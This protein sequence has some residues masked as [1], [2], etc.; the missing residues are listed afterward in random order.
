MAS[1]QL[2]LD[3]ASPSGTITTQYGS[4][5]VM[6]QAT[7]AGSA[8]CADCGAPVAPDDRFCRSCGRPVSASLEHTPQHLTE[9]ILAQRG[10]LIGERKQV[11]VLFADIVGSTALVRE[12]DPEQASAVITPIVE[13]MMAA[14]HQFEG[15]VTQIAGDGI[16]ALFGAP[17]AV[18]DHAVRACYGAVDILRNVARVTDGSVQVRVGLHSGQVLVKAIEKDLSI[19]YTA[20]GATVHLAARLEKAARPGTA[21]ATTAT[22][23]LARGFV[24]SRPV[25]PIELAGY[26]TPVQV[27]ELRGMR[28]LEGT[29]Q[30]RAQRKLT[31][32]VARSGEM[33]VLRRA[34]ATAAGGAGQVVAVV[35]EA[36]VGK[37]RLL[38]EFNDVCRRDDVQMLTGAATPYDT[39]TPYH[40]LKGLVRTWAGLG[41]GDAVEPALA[42][43]L[44]ERS[45]V[46]AL[47]AM[48]DGR[49]SDPVW[50][51]LDPRQRRRAMR[52][53]VRSVLLAQ[54][55]QAPLLVLI[56]DLHWL[57]TE[58]QA[59]LD[60]LV[61]SLPSSRLL[62]VVTYRPEYEHTWASQASYTQL[63]VE[64]L[65]GADAGA[66]LDALLGT[67]PSTAALGTGL[68]ARSEGTPLFLEEWVNALIEEGRLVGS[69]GSY[70]LV[71]DP[72]D[73]AMP[74]TVQTILAAR[75]DRL[76]GALKSVLRVASV[77][78]EQVPFTLLAPLC[79]VD[80]LEEA[81]G[82]LEA[83][84]FLY[85]HRAQRE[86]REGE[87]ERQ[88]AGGWGSEWAFK[89]NL[90]REVVYGSTPLELRR[91]L[92][93]RV[94]DVLAGVQPEQ[95]ERLAHHAWNAQRWSAAARY[96]RAAGDK[97]IERSAYPAA[98]R[99]FGQALSALA[100]APQDRAHL[101]LA[102]DVRLAQRV[103]VMATGGK[104]ADSLA[105]L[106][107]ASVIAARIADGHRQALAEI[108]RSYAAS[109]MGDNHIGV[110]A[111]EAALSVA[112]A[113]DDTAVSSEARIAIAQ[114]HLYAG[115]WEPVPDLLAPDLGFLLSD[116]HRLERR[117]Q[118]A[119]RSLM[120]LSHLAMAY[121]LA[122][123]DAEAL[124]AISQAEQLTRQSRRPLDRC[125]VLW[126]AGDVHRNA[127]RSADA[128]PLLETGY[129]LAR[130]HELTWW[131]TL[132][133]PE[134]AA[135]LAADGR[136]VEAA[137]VIKR[138][139]QPAL[140]T[141]FPMNQTRALVHAAEVHVACG[142]PGQ[143]REHAMEA[144]RHCAGFDHPLFEA[145]ALRW[146]G[147][148]ATLLGDP[149]QAIDALSG[150]LRLAESLRAHLLTTSIR[151]DLSRLPAIGTGR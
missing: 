118:A 46:S 45:H 16:M 79:A 2:A 108:H 38:H 20:I 42:Q 123:R 49:P 48:L 99:F 64:P 112:R 47:T 94:V 6:G 56:E 90:T 142:E 91:R 26:T 33:A 119:T 75:V 113:M 5:N 57:D 27:H 143:A 50:F 121:S 126:S 93:G 115:R 148:A 62:L 59:V 71:G 12:I 134:L 78:G 105:E 132:L 23:N 89:H 129:G 72:T 149:Q 82:R 7:S 52:D 53:A 60:E 87:G 122:G 61:G 37:S 51:D 44:G 117:G 55:G 131:A 145:H 80:D 15:T 136:H 74:S 98:R 125:H 144:L 100:N 85:P 28:A 41:A 19:D 104:L 1:V 138:A 150:A 109:T 32:F 18:E 111:G 140:A 11:T 4:G 3:G 43:R 120:S 35:G 25:G 102:V 97:A 147:V 141:G 22:I 88:R 128:V 81:L 135:A 58:S 8:R 29:W 124:A 116:A 101:E 130:E 40:P 86:Q 30:V 17:L 84:E 92:H 73:V 151:Q 24:D 76:G 63:R 110:Q 106:A 68:L 139:L 34:L 67:D 103:A 107:Q 36:G 10:D 69:P 31:P 95:T 9:R 54:A 39:L 96:S 13:S 14:V 146:L 127:G 77:I 66:F 114:A 70:R 83:A 137:D 21:L 133:G 65:R